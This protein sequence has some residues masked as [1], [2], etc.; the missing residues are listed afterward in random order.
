MAP[1]KKDA[2]GLI[3]GPL[4]VTART[5][6]KDRDKRVVF[7]ATCIC[8]AVEHGALAVLGQFQGH[9]LNC[10]GHPL[11]KCNEKPES[12]FTFFPDQPEYDAALA[13]WEAA[14][15]PGQIEVE[16]E[17]NIAANT[18]T[19]EVMTAESAPVVTTTEPE[20]A[21]ETASMIEIIADTSADIITTADATTDV[22]AGTPA[23][24][25]KPPKAV[26]NKDTS[27]KMS[28]VLATRLKLT[29]YHTVSKKLTSPVKIL[30]Q[31][32]VSVVF[33]ED[34]TGTDRV[35]LHICLCSTDDKK[36]KSIVS[37]MRKIPTDDFS[38]LTS[39]LAEMNVTWRSKDQP[40]I[41]VAK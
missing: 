41:A 39:T 29:N 9:G 3:A 17:V 18:T 24:S 33:A 30:G 14:R 6:R 37:S 27:A 34:A 4:K 32:A 12:G 13:A 38:T 28:A 40:Q 1:Q 8:G 7:T 36:S 31:D 11:K 16:S 23:V 25:Q 35:L 21:V 2:T 26:V 22:I 15:H 20:T 10:P 19:P 5:D